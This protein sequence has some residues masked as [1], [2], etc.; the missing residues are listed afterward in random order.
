MGIQ[1]IIIMILVEFAG[2]ICDCYPT[3]LRTHKGRGEAAI[4]GRKTAGAIYSLLQSIAGMWF[5]EIYYGACRIIDFCKIDFR[6]CIG[7]P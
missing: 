2:K 6:S 3:D 4:Q 7:A 5:Q 1:S